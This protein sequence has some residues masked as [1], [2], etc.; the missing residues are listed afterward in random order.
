MDP[1]L[2]TSVAAAVEEDR[3]LSIEALATAH[4]TL[5]STIHTVHHEDLGPEKRSARWVPKLLNDNKN[6]S[7]SRSARSSSWHS[8][9]TLGHAGLHCHHGRDNGVFSHS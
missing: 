7:V 2:I 1:A 8:T 9:A 5:V 4:R 3:R 6:N